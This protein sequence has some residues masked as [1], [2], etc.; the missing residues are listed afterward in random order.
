MFKQAND[1]KHTAKVTRAWFED[2]ITV[3]KWPSQ[4]PD[5]TPVE[6]LWILLKNSLCKRRPKDLSEL[7]FSCK[8]RM[9]KHSNQNMWKSIETGCEL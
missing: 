1:P 4:S 2:N 9:A 8:G 6:N 7:K 3:M 5:M